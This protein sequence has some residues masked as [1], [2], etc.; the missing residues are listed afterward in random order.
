MKWKYLALMVFLI[1]ALHGGAF[2]VD[3]EEA[4]GNVIGGNLSGFLVL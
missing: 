2:A 3:T 4:S 1:E